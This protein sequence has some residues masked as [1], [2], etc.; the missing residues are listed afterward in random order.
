MVWCVASGSSAMLHSRPT[1]SHPGRRRL[2]A[3]GIPRQHATASSRCR[4]T[5]PPRQHAGRP[6][7]AAD[8]GA[9]PSPSTDC[10][11]AVC[12]CRNPRLGRD[13]VRT[14]VLR[15][16]QGSSPH[17]WRPDC[18]ARACIGEMN[19]KEHFSL[20]YQALADSVRVP[21]CW[22]PLAP[23]DRKAC[24]QIKELKE[25]PQLFRNDARQPAQVLN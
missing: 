20:S 15:G 6:L 10:V 23:S 25:H 7:H 11:R 12:P 14:F 24:T 22:C 21:R 4:V 3:T 8:H 2:H 1:K 17:C 5:M 9:R 13:C 19:W 16:V 18:K